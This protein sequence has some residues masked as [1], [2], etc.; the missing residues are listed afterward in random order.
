MSKTILCLSTLALLLVAAGVQ[1]D[2]FV[3]GSAADTWTVKADPNSH[4]S[5]PYI[6]VHGG[7]IDRT[8]YVRFDLSA[9]QGMNI[10]SATVTF[11]MHGSIP[12][13]P[14]RNDSIVTGRISLYG[15][16][17]VAGNTAQNWDEALLTSSTTGAEADWTT[18]TIITAG[19]LTTDLDGD[20][21]GVTEAVINAAAGAAALGTKV[22]VTGATLVSWLQSRVDAGGLVTFILKNDDGS[23]RGFGFCSKEY[24][25]VTYAPKLEVTA[26]AKL[27][28]VYV[29]DSPDIDKDGAMD[30]E[31]V[32]SW[33]AAQG[34]NVDARRGYWQVLDANKIAE[35]NAADVIIAGCGLSTGNYDDGD[36]ITQWNSL[37]APMI[38]LNSWLV[39]NNRWKWMNSGTAVKDAG[40]PL[41]MPTVAAHPV[42]AG[43]T[44]DANGLV[45]VLDAGVGNGQ[46]SFLQ[47]IVDAGNGKLLA[48]T[49]GKYT[50]AWI[51]EWPAGV[52]YY[53][54]ATQFTGGRRMMFM[55]T[56][57]ETGAP[58]R[59][60]EFNLNE[61]GQ[62]IFRNMIAYLTQAPVAGL[63]HQ[64]TFADGTAND[65]I[66]DANGVLVGGAKVE[67]GALVT[68]AQD[69]WMEMPGDTI[70]V[71]TYAAVTIEAWYTPAAN[72]NTSWTM[73]AYFGASDSG[74]GND[75]F[76]ITSARG[77][78]VSRAAISCGN[79]SAPYSVESGVNGPEYDDGLLHQMIATIDA[80]DI[81]LYIDG[82]LCAKTALSATNKLSLVS[83]KLAY[84]AKGGYGGDPEW[85]GVIHTFSIYSKAATAAEVQQLFWEGPK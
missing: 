75:G 48:T 58:S 14:Y 4:S 23:D 60:A 81:A 76:F 68:T 79:V 71:N 10:E 62:L 84:L 67:N 18:G 72:A 33:L 77:D 16:N 52:E 28:V 34:Y 27:N 61:T 7:S 25:D 51:A 30:D 19:G 46:T 64:Y 8:G 49:V 57:Q 15:L 3:V 24:A 37:K 82:A 2:T 9:L 13:P 44:P 1:A 26:K 12:K 69:Q 36:E 66:G 63:T 70:A 83:N 35:L 42:F 39:R 31:S 80:N 21:N 65:S 73:L 54:G 22:T 29:T 20:V 32:V 59:Q 17:D 40:A 5:D 53:A 11:N 41:M 50:T 43:V 74:S 56:Q 85:I 55:A 45:S 78:N 38:N 47:D 6:V